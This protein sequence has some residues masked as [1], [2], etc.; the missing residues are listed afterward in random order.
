MH[1]RRLIG[2]GDFPRYRLADQF[3]GR[4]LGG[5]LL[6]LKQ[7]RGNRADR[8]ANREFVSPAK[9]AQLV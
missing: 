3:V 5:P 1:L 6:A 9:H 2:R 4:N 8:N 7:G